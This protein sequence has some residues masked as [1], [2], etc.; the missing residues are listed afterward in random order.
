VWV[1]TVKL[2]W[3]I[4]ATKLSDALSDVMPMCVAKHGHLWN[5]GATRPYFWD[6]RLTMLM[7]CTIFT[8]CERAD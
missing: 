8:I 1:L 4:D 3:L 7:E 2:R 6:M 5:L